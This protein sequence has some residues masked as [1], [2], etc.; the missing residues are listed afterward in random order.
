MPIGQIIAALLLP[1][2]GV[3]LIEGLSRDFWIDL[4]LTC[5]G[6][7]PGVVF[8]LIV[9]TRNRRPDPQPA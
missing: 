2:L 7:V 5:L 4:A 6:L 1:P 3:Y 9:V 8:A